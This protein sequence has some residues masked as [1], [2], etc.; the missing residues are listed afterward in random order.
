MDSVV[1]SAAGQI[2]CSACGDTVVLERGQTAM[3]EKIAAF[4]DAHHNC[5]RIHI[6]LGAAEHP[7]QST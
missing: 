6:D 4:W 3:R 1:K 2:S 7:S 5:G